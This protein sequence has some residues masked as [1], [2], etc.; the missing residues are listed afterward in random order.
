M[1]VPPYVCRKSNFATLAV[2]CLVLRLVTCYIVNYKAASNFVF[3]YFFYNEDRRP[4][5]ESGLHNEETKQF[6][7]FKI[8]KKYF[9]LQ[10]IFLTIFIVYS[11]YFI[12]SI[13]WV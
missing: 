2:H 13:H 8:H 9:W 3:Y 5:P 11:F 6:K 1:S 4:Q 12:Y 7:G 10:R